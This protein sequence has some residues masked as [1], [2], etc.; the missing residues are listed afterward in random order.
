MIAVN[1]NKQISA[2]MSQV[3]AEHII[4]CLSCGRSTLTTTCV[5]EGVLSSCH[6]DLE[7]DAK[8]KGCYLVCVCFQAT[9]ICICSSGPNSSR[10]TLRPQLASEPASWS[11]ASSK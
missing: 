9:Y 2:E 1:S 10:P 11:A 3:I 5:C 4:G 6:H 8:V 7:V